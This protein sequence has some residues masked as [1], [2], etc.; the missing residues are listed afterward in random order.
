MSDRDKLID[1]AIELQQISQSA[2]YFCKNE[3]DIERFE[4][5]R[6]ISAEIM[7]LKS[8]LDI[9]VVK[10][11]FCNEVGYQTPKIDTRAALF[12]DNK[13]LLVQ[14]NT[15]FWALPGGWADIGN[16][17]KENALREL[18]EEAGIKG[19]AKTLVACIDKSYSTLKR[20][21]FGVYSFLI[22]CEYIEGEFKPNIETI[23]SD[24][25]SRDN[26][27]ELA[28]FKTT[29]EQIDLSFEAHFSQNWKTR[30]D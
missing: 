1:W 10:G 25:F 3:Y 15:G 8:G 21:P 9:N 18:W 27:P 19:E 28:P 17:L 13:I 23:A 4:R 14:E 22:L 11:L 26:L 6:Q 16:S 24:Y 12:R 29:I 30:F 7:A 20:H 5:V 2:L